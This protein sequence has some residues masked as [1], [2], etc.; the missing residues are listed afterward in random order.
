[1]IV[2]KLLAALSCLALA[3][4]AFAQA[5]APA[6]PP[7]STMERLSKA[8]KVR[9]G[10]KFDQPLLSQK[11]LGGN[12]EGFDVEI[13]KIVAAALGIKPDN[14]EWVETVS[15]NR[16]PFI[17]Q[18]KVDFVVA[19]YAINDK[20]KQIITF[21]GPYIVGGEDIMVKKGN[22]LNIK[23]PQDLD[24][25]RACSITGSEGIKAIQAHTKAVPVGFDVLSKCGE[26][27]K[28]GAVDAVVVT[29]NHLAGYV[30]RD[31]QAFEVL[32]KRMTREP[33][34][35]GMKKGDVQ[36]CE[37]IHATLKQAEKDGRYQKAYEGSLGRIL[38]S[39]PAVP[40]FDRCI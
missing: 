12:L 7:G 4:T 33:W 13:A 22:P 8:G 38:K 40:E 3:G 30:S 15:V 35:I 17:M 23:G 24:G 37:F 34:G 25:K 18:G 39:T 14:I 36:F 9:I 31:P 26:A 27:L 6:F 20:R 10:A 16:E 2:R 28:T 1:M 11:S 29:D 5:P 21:A 32:G 19:S